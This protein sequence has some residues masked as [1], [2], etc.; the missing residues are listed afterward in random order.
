MDRHECEPIFTDE[1]VA[2]GIFEWVCVT[3]GYRVRFEAGKKT[4]RR[5]GDESVLH[6]GNT[7][8]VFILSSKA[9]EEA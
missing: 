2:R 5:A 1:Q 8:G 4:V 9:E 3:C 6:Y 7:G